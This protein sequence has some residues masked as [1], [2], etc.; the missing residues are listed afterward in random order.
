MTQFRK[1][2]SIGQY[3]NLVKNVR[4]WAKYNECPMPVLRFKGTTKLHGTN[5]AVGYN[6]TTK[7][8][9][10]QSRER[11]ITYEDDNAGFAA[12]VETNATRFLQTLSKIETF[13]NE[14]MVW[15]RNSEGCCGQ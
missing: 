7:E 14:I 11:V 10:A 13:S 15:P 6:P 2:P 8:L 4:S 1:F 9:W 12:F 5:A 3:S